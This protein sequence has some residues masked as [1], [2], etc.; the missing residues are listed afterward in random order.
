MKKLR[1]S[2]RK[3][4]AISKSDKGDAHSYLEF[5]DLL[6]ARFTQDKTSL[7][8]I[9]VKSGG[10]LS[11]FK[12]YFQPGS[13]IHGIEN[14]AVTVPLNGVAVFFG[15][16]YTEEMLS[17]LGQYDIIIDD[18]SHK[19]Q[20]VQFFIKHYLNKVNPGGLLIVEDVQPGINTKDLFESVPAE[21]RSCA[22]IIDCRHAKGRNDD[23]LFVI[24][25]VAQ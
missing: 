1:D 10:S 14:Q 8:E 13:V 25:K 19:L 11:M 18:G 4:Q 20:D 6:F 21:H 9:G 7:L 24:Y 3:S 23:M 2:W 17:V 16:A 15:N 22:Y 5:Y 12:D